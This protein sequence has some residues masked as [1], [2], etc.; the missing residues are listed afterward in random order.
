MPVADLLE[1]LEKLNDELRRVDQDQLPAQN[2]TRVAQDLA[3]QNLLAHKDKG[4]RAST[5]CCLVDVMRI[6]A[7][8]AP[9][10]LGQIK[11]RPWQEYRT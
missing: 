1:R 7:P 2:F 5:C 11:V 9:L 3:N 4:V 6:C 8:D 10:K